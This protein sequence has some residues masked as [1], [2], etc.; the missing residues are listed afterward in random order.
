MRHEIRIVKDLMEQNTWNSSLVVTFYELSKCLVEW[1]VYYVFVALISSLLMSKFRILLRSYERHRNSAIKINLWAFTASL[2]ASTTPASCATWIVQFGV[3]YV[4]PIVEELVLL[5]IPFSLQLPQ[6]LCAQ[7]NPKSKLMVLV[8]VLLM[9]YV[10][11]I[12]YP[13]TVPTP[14][15]IKYSVLGLSSVM[16]ISFQV[17]LN[18]FFVVGF[19]FV[20]LYS[21]LISLPPPIIFLL[22][23]IIVLSFFWKVDVRFFL[24]HT[25]VQDIF[26]IILVILGDSHLLQ[27]HITSL[28]F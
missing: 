1:D 7:E 4:P 8:F 27:N 25:Y 11:Y 24:Q 10:C 17:R 9:A 26:L 13:H 16:S 3:S 15:Y 6:V 21:D 19:L 23:V 12:S 2:L 22:K 5:I 20:N 18:F 14:L 28:P